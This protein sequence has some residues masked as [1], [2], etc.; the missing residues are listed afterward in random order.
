VSGFTAYVGCSFHP[1]EIL[2]ETGKLDTDDGAMDLRGWFE[3]QD[4]DI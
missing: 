2:N 4:R 3:G 1:E